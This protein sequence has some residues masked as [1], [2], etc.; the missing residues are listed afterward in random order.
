[1]HAVI[2]L[3]TTSNITIHTSTIAIVPLGAI[4]DLP[5]PWQT[6]RA[7]QRLRPPLLPLLHLHLFHALHATTST[8]G[9][10]R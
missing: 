2:L 1:V 6:T 10:R 7:N 4:E 3:A 8:A 5:T 9:T